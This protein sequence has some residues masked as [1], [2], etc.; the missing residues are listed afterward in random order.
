MNSGEMEEQQHV[1]N[2][3]KINRFENSQYYL[4]P[5]TDDDINNNIGINNEQT[6]A[7]TIATNDFKE[8]DVELSTNVDIAQH[9]RFRDVTEY[10]VINDNKELVLYRNRL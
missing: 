6:A 9:D 10:S 5:L 1:N 8:S 3:K 7:T 2:R 4:M